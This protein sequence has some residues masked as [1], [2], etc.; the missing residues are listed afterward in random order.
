MT[1]RRTFGVL[2]MLVGGG[3]LLKAIIWGP[4]PSDVYPLLA[5]L[6]ISGFLESYF[7]RE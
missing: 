5:V 1:V 2:Q 4:S 3:F 6:C 7:P